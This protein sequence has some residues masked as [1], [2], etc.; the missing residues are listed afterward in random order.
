MFIQHSSIKRQE[1]G[2]H[3]RPGLVQAVG[4]NPNLS[5]ASGLNLKEKVR[6]AEGRGTR[7]ASHIERPTIPSEACLPHS[8]FAIRHS[9]FIVTASVA[10]LH[11][12]LPAASRPIVIPAKACLRAARTG[13]PESRRSNVA[14]DSERP[15]QSSCSRPIPTTANSP[16]PL[17][18]HSL[19]QRRSLQS[20]QMQNGECRKQCG[21]D[22]RSKCRSERLRE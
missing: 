12:A 20:G 5:S 19:A 18:V 16:R 10:S 4:A 3:R 15:R 8:A 1:R 13:R 2:L 7:H 21:V 22:R 11:R 9:P 14:H 17:I 6:A